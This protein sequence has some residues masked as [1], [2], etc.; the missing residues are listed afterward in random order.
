MP[1]Y[2]FKTEDGRIVERNF[3]ISD[4]PTEITLDDGV[5][6][7]RDLGTEHARRGRQCGGYK[8]F[9]CY[10]IGVNPD[11]IPELR[12]VLDANGCRNTEIS[13][14]G[15]PVITSESQYRRVRKAVGVHPHNS[16]T[17]Q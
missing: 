17:S 12:A 2:C 8:Q 3:R 13:R 11:Q 16:Y 6:A 14:D 7:R 1:I 4:R 15:D 9:D 10:A 5:I